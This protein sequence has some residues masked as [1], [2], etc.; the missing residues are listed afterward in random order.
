MAYTYDPA[1]PDAMNVV[2]M[3]T[4]V[5]MDYL[6]MRQD[7]KLGVTTLPTGYPAQQVYLEPEVVWYKK[8]I[9]IFAGL[10]VVGTIIYM[11][12]KRKRA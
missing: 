9:V 6:K 8:P 3:I 2:N 4:N 11:V 1:A 12:A 7:A 10:A 5:A